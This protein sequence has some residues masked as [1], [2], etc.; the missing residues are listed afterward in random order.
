MQS[1]SIFIRKSGSTLK[2][3]KNLH[4]QMIGMNQSK[5]RCRQISVVCSKK[6]LVVSSTPGRFCNF[7]SHVN[8]I[9]LFLALNLL[10]NCYI[11]MSIV[12]F[13]TGSLIIN[14]VPCF[15]Y[16]H[17]APEGLSSQ[18]EETWNQEDFKNLSF[19]VLWWIDKNLEVQ[20]RLISKKSNFS[21][22]LRE[23]FKN[24]KIDLWIGENLELQPE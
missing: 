18:S 12:F 5:P 2:V 23:T 24:P 17:T 15:S 14:W 3:K 10:Q 9:T 13:K 22:P 7:S 11:S 21:S 4:W 8:L 19:P 6:S 1:S 20:S 16:K